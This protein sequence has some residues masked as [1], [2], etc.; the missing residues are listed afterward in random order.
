MANVTV[1]HM[2]IQNLIEFIQSHPENTFTYVEAGSKDPDNYDLANKGALFLVRD[3]ESVESIANNTKGT[4]S[5]YGEIY[6]R[7]DSPDGMQGYAKLADLEAAFNKILLEWLYSVSKNTAG[8]DVIDLRISD[9]IGDAD[10]LR[11]I[12]GSRS[13]VKIIWSNL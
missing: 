8:I 4:V 2:I 9:V 6:T 11:P 1:W 10:S 13:T 7:D 5:L 12:L 3:R